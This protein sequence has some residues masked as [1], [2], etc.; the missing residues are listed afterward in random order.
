MAKCWYSTVVLLGCQAP[1]AFLMK[2]LENFCS[3]MLNDSMRKA[4]FLFLQVKQE[5]L[6]CS[7][8]VTLLLLFMSCFALPF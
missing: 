8:Y 3:E 5:G 7:V 2:V 4:V 1:L 6:V